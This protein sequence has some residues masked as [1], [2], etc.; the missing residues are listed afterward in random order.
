MYGTAPFDDYKR[1]SARRT[2]PVRRGT[3]GK[4]IAM[5]TATI[6]NLAIAISDIDLRWVALQ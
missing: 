5:T 6:N 1:M 4:G 2:M 3:I